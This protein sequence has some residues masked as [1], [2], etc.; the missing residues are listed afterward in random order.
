MDYFVLP[1]TDNIDGYENYDSNTIVNIVL[2][3]A[4]NEHVQLVFKVNP[5]EHYSIS[6]LQNKSNIEINC[7]KIESINGF[8][9]VLVPVSKDFI[10]QDSIAKLWISF[11]TNHKSVPGVYNHKLIIEGKQ[12]KLVVPITIKVYNVELPLKPSIPAAFG[13][14]EKNLPYPENSD[15]EAKASIREKW[16][17][18]CLDYKINPY[19]STWLESSMKHEA[20]SSP[21]AWNDTRTYQFLADE[22]FNR[23]ALPYHS[24]SKEEL[25]QMLQTYERKDILP[26][27]YFYLWDEPVLTSEYKQINSFAKTIHEIAPQ[28]KVL[29]TFYCGPQ[30]GEFKDQLFSVFD[31]W[32][33]YTQIYCMSA[34]ALQ[35]DENKADTARL[36]LRNHDEWWTYV[37]MGPGGK[38]PNLLLSMTGYQHRAVLWRSWKEKTSGFLYWA[39]NAFDNMQNLTFRKDLPEGDGVLIYPG[40]IMNSQDPLVSVR[41]ERWRDSMEDYEYLTLLETKIGRAEAE[42]I[43]ESIYQSPAQYADNYQLINKFRENV[44]IIIQNQ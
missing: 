41:L 43:F 7:R 28:A 25:N 1:S 5:N 38:E 33:D 34:W 40:E 39:V 24:L 17:N 16:A 44:L 11:K 35:T 14:I 15:R 31:L 22:R 37:C 4:D 6:N 9:D 8:D 36:L 10:I 21:W 19:F 3:K 27:A 42:T 23:Y 12:S 2:A 18:L 32:K 26:Q 29:T 30:D 20:Y 13:I